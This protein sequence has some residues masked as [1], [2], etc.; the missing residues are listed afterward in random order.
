MWIFKIVYFIF[1]GKI[2]ELLV[3][4]MV[5]NMIKFVLVNVIYFKGNW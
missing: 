5:D 4:G 2:S 1:L 3:K